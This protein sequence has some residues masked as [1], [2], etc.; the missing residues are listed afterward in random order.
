MPKRDLSAYDDIFQSAGRE[1]NVD[2]LL[3]K[4]MATQ[5]SAGD[6]KAISK[7]GAMGLMQIMPATAKGLGVTNAFDPVQSIY[8][9]AKLMDEALRAEG[10]AER[11]LL[12]YHGGPAWRRAYGPESRAYVPAV[13]GHY[14]SLVSEAAATAKATAA[15]PVAAVEGDPDGLADSG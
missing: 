4:A 11:A 1:W 14:Q 9:A 7:A 8:G 5:E 10:S 13:A 3:L 2:P 6:P 15:S 12:Y